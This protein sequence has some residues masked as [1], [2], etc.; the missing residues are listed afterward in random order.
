ML[1]RWIVGALFA[2]RKQRSGYGIA[3]A[4]AGLTRRRA[5]GREKVSVT[6]TILE[7]LCEPKNRS[8]Y[9][10]PRS[11]CSPSDF[12]RKLSPLYIFFLH[13]S[14]RGGSIAGCHAPVAFELARSGRSKGSIS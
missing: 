12:V 3:N 10:A 11:F 4:E 1:A 13:W 8:V 6:P 14:W 5:V 7:R 9:N 2:Q